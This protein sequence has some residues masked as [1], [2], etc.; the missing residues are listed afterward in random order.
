MLSI[1]KFRPNYDCSIGYEVMNVIRGLVMSLYK[2][3][4][5]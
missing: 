4:S 1:I 3:E 2:F 5:L